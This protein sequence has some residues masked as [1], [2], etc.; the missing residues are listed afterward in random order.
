MNI[1][2]KICEGKILEKHFILAVEDD[3]IWYAVIYLSWNFNR[4]YS[5]HCNGNFNCNIKV[6]QYLLAEDCSHAIH[7]NIFQS[8]IYLI[9]HTSVTFRVKSS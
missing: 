4:N 9:L 2:M 1:G 5:Y 3:M 7:K 8:Y 6:V